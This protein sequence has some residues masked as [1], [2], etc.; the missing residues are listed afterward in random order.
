MKKKKKMYAEANEYLRRANLRRAVALP[1]RASSRTR[2]K[3]KK[4]KK[5]YAEADEYLRRANMRGA[6][7]FPARVSSR[8]RALCAHLCVD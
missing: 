1:A 8:K 7:A 4:N 3:R 2:G 5:S 6:K